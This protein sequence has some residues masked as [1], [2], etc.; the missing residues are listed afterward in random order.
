M[1]VHT[2]RQELRGRI[3]SDTG[4]NTFA[5]VLKDFSEQPGKDGFSNMFE[6]VDADHGVELTSRKLAKW[7]VTRVVE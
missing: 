3:A 5:R 1:G 7:F 6:Y 2:I 4:E